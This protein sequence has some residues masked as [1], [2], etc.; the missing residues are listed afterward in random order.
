[1]IKSIHLL[2]YLDDSV[3][4]DITYHMKEEIYLPNDII[5]K[6][7]THATCMYFLYS[8]TVC[9]KTPNGKE[10]RFLII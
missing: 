6:S 2:R 9:I 1:M 7:N 3:I 8:G 4:D 5:I 10:V